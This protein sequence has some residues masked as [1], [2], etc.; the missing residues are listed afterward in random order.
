MG[1]FANIAFTPRV[2]A[3]QERM[4]SRRAYAHADGSTA[5]D[6]IGDSEEEFLAARDS[7]YM[8][9]IGETGWPYIQHRGGPKGFVKVLDPHTIGFT[10]YR[11][12]KQ[13]V[14]L[15]NI[16]GDDRV[17]LI[18]VDY[19]NRARLKVLA[20][21]AVVTAESAPDVIKA[22]TVGMGDY[23]ARVERG[24]VLRVEGLDWNCPQHITPRFTEDEARES[25]A[26]LLQR[27]EAAEAENR[28]LRASL[29]KL[30]V[31]ARQS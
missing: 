7:F 20:R 27:L 14:S 10:D 29:A 12:N 15:G 28:E 1:R 6:D 25:V 11:G 30:R 26:P 13:Y 2:K 9:S 8:A 31:H 21:A 22:L 24:F 17:A 18:F 3:E 16:G 4:G 5:P 23:A 19:P